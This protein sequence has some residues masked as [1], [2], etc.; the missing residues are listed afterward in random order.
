VRHATLDAEL[1]LYRVESNG[2][3]SNIALANRRGLGREL[4]VWNETNLSTNYVVAVTSYN[5]AFEVD[6]CY[7]LLVE[8]ADTLMTGVS[9]L[10]NPAFQFKIAPNP[11]T[12]EFRVLVAM[13]IIQSLENQLIV[14]D[15]LGRKVFSRG[16]QPSDN[17]TPI[18]VR[19]EGWSKGMYFVSIQRDGQIVTEKL[20]IE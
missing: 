15:M 4:L 11:A 20:L 17:N 6:S 8:N 19:T 2:D 7:S 5:G 10:P 18:T 3:L 9:T 13:E 12:D 16:L 1:Q 14:R